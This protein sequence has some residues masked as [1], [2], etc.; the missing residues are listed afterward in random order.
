MN[1]FKQIIKVIY[2]V[3]QEMNTE[4][5]KGVVLKF[6]ENIQENVE[7]VMKLAGPIMQV[8]G[9]DMGFKTRGVGNA[10]LR[11]IVQE[12]ELEEKRQ[13]ALNN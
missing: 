2:S 7:L 11:E 3:L 10:L 4:E 1:K 12:I 9:F 8:F 13:S 5:N 6:G